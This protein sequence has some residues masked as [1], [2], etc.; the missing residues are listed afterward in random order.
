MTSHTRS[1]GLAHFSK[2]DRVQKE[3]IPVVFS[4]PCVQYLYVDIYSLLDFRFIVFKCQNCQCVQDCCNIFFIDIS[5]GGSN[6]DK[7]CSL[8][9]I[10]YRLAC[11]KI[12]FIIDGGVVMSEPGRW[13]TPHPPPPKKGIPSLSF[14]TKV[15]LESKS[16]R[17]VLIGPGPY[18][19]SCCEIL[20][21]ATAGGHELMVS[22][23][24]WQT[25]LC[26]C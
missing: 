6:G 10:K 18:P 21:G 25:V 17:V 13:Y 15:L 23:G 9:R 20:A 19:S 26:M 24:T 12:Y 11:L 14:L 3:L 7:S 2:G 5:W 8:C 16:R 22:G 4:C 1:F